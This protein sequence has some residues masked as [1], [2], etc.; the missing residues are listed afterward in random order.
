MK[1]QP[2]DVQI[3]DVIYSSKRK[4]CETAVDMDIEGFQSHEKSGISWKNHNFKK[5]GL[6]KIQWHEI[7]LL[8]CS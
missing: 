8:P 3:A 4:I 2:P 7:L 5:V 1:S 6:L